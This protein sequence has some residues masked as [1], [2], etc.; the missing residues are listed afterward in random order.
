[1]TVNAI[2]KV[3]GQKVNLNLRPA[4]SDQISPGKP[5]GVPSWVPSEMAHDDLIGLDMDPITVKE[6]TDLGMCSNVAKCFYFV[7]ISP[8][9]SSSAAS[10]Q[11][12]S[13]ESNTSEV[14]SMEVS[15]SLTDASGASYGRLISNSYGDHF[16]PDDLAGLELGPLIGSGGFGKGECLARFIP[17]YAL[18]TP[19]NHPLHI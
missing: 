10:S 2:H 16:I 19:M 12:T 15:G 11:R 14:S 8:Y 5:V 4:S 18:S 3:T 17:S 13:L 6:H 1:M 9:A 7:V